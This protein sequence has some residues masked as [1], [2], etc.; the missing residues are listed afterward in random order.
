M[1]PVQTPALT[2][3][4]S[5]DYKRNPGYLCA[6][7][8][9]KCD[10]PPRHPVKS[11]GDAFGVS[12]HF[13]SQKIQNAIAGPISAASKGALSMLAIPSDPTSFQQRIVDPI[14]VAPISEEIA[15][16]EI[17]QKLAQTIFFIRL[18][19]RAMIARHLSIRFVIASEV[20]AYLTCIF[21]TWA[22]IANK[23]PSIG[24]VWFEHL[25]PIVEISLLLPPLV[26]IIDF[27]RRKE[28]SKNW[29]NERVRPCSLI[30][31]YDWNEEDM[32]GQPS[33]RLRIA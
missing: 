8:H 17:C 25:F 15:F 29:K 11:R 27:L 14:L 9:R 20:A 10:C 7:D 33:S 24:G 28:S 4:W 13:I 16:R 2:H 6:V 23:R 21:H 19:V 26:S 1:V 31:A 12:F 18:H 3:I 30:E 32:Y 5:N 22:G